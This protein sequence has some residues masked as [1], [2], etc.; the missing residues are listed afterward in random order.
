MASTRTLDE[1]ISQLQ[2]VFPSIEGDVIAVV[3]TEN[4]YD[5]GSLR[6]D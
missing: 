2:A 4:G 3:L 1:K 5:G 6:L